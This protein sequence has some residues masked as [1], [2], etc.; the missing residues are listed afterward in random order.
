MYA[1]GFV[2]RFRRDSDMEGLHELLNNPVR[3]AVHDS[4]SNTPLAWTV[5]DVLGF[6]LG[7]QTLD[8]DTLVLEMDSALP[9]GLPKVGEYVPRWT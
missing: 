2:G 3:I 1:Y 8:F 9:A 4:V 5:V 7:K 6:G